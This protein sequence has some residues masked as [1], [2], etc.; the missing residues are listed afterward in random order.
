MFPFLGK[1]KTK[2]SLKP[3]M[4]ITAHA[5]SLSDVVEK[6]KNNSPQDVKLAVAFVSHEE[7][8]E[9]VTSQIKEA[10]PEDSVLIGCTDAGRLNSECSDQY[11]QSRSASPVVVQTYHKR[12]VS[13]FEIKTLDLH[14]GDSTLTKDERV[15]RIRQEVSKISTKFPVS[16]EDTVGFALIDGLSA[17]ESFFAEAVFESRNLPFHIVGGSAGGSLNFDITK[18]YDGSRV[19]T[20]RAVLA[21]VKLGG[22]YTYNVHSHHNFELTSTSF[23]VVESSLEERWVKQVMDGKGD[24]TSFIDA[25][26]MELKVS[27][28]EGLQQKLVDYSFAIVV[29]GKPMIRSVAFFDEPQG[30][31]NFYCDV[32]AGDTLHL[33][34]RK[35]LKMCFD[36]AKREVLSTEHRFVGGIAVD[37]IL[38]RLNNKNELSSSFWG[39]GSNVIGFSSFGE[40]WGLNNNETQ[41]G[42]YF[43]ERSDSGKKPHSVE[44]FPFIYASQYNYF[45]QRELQKKLVLEEVYKSIIDEA[46]ALSSQVPELLKFYSIIERSIVDVN[47]ATG[48]VTAELD[49]QLGKLSVIADINDQIIPRTSMLTQA[50]GKIEGVMKVIQNI[51]EQ[52]NLLALNAAIEAARAGEHGRGFAVVADEVRTLAISTTKSLEQS[53]ENI[54]GLMSEV[55]AINTLLD[56]RKDD[57]NSVSKVSDVAHQLIDDISSGLDSVSQTLAP[58]MEEA[59]RISELAISSKKKIEDSIEIREFLK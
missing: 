33:V 59:V 3:E 2:E 51:A 45:S 28:L 44:K 58:A 14:C 20:G 16:H 35:S 41:T 21:I 7:N 29:D 40:F 13:D 54:S 49:G 50:T 38:R 31:V 52:T 8:F 37:C 42:L 57:F 48:E 6:I 22:E 11:H 47:D 24:I 4:P 19:L 23:K 55:N 15:R 34:R 17:S 30:R 53:S 36:N 39:A 26:M 5:G 56:D 10:L 43:F 32:A 18:V 25:L 27:S 1:G 9:R 12:L 46:V